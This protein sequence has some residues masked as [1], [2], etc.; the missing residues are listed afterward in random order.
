[1]DIIRLSRSIVGQRELDAVARVLLEDGYLGMGGET[2][3]FEYELATFLGRTPGE[4]ACM[5]S[6]TAAVHLAVQSVLNP[7]D[8]ILVQSL[9]FVATFQAISAAGARPIACEI[10][11]ETFTIDLKD[12]AKRLT[13]RCKAIMP[14]HYASYPSNIDEVYAFAKKH[15]LRVIEDAAHAFGC[16]NRGRKIGG[17][18]DIACFSFDGIKNITCG[19]GGMVSSSDQTVMSKVRDSR[20]LGVENDTEKR[21]SNRRSWEFD[22]KNQGY[23]YHMSN[24]NAAIG[25]VQLSRL[26][27]EFAPKRREL[28]QIY[29]ERLSEVPGVRLLKTDL[30]EVIPHLQPVLILDGKRDAVRVG[31]EAAG[32]QSGIHYKPNHLLTMYSANNPRL[33]ITEHV[34][35]EMLSL[36]LHP[37]LSTMDVNRVCDTISIILRG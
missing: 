34:Y 28:A 4:V 36:P 17:F 21:Y 26:D 5:N 19:E 24:I 8:E 25:R 2:K 31:L 27:T 30:S 12:A 29:R 35:S 11:P 23:R 16:T 7:S 22:V 9:T 37:G 6:G 3:S 10:D 1:M 33:A 15:G 20:L 32:I 18:G 13:P 14:V